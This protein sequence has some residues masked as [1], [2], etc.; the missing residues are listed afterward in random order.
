[1]NISKIVFLFLTCL[2]MC[3][4]LFGQDDLLNM[5]LK[6]AKSEEKNVSATF[7]TTKLINA[8]TNETVHK[9][10]LDFR[11]AH[12]FGNVGKYSEGKSP[13]HTIYGL[14]ASTDIRIAFDYGITDRLTVGISRT[15][16]RENLEG[17]VKYRVLQ[18]TMDNKIPVALTVFGN[19]TYTPVRDE[20]EIYKKAAHR[21]TYFAQAIIAR[22]F[23]NKLS[24]EI[25]P[26]YLHR[27]LVLDPA[28]ENDLFSLGGGVR[29]KITKSTSVI[30]DYFH[31]F[32][33][34]RMD[35]S[36]SYFDP[37]GVGFEI[38]TGGHV[39]SIMFTNSAG[40]LENEFLPYTTDSWAEGGFKFSFNISR[41]FK[42]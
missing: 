33:K 2:F 11:V 25:L 29:Y 36:D 23:S 17:Q 6:E 24:F 38:E 16:I 3:S 4:N 12:R 39:F 7:K 8:Q 22:K 14:D 37:L 19:A 18:Q 30:I 10:T 40:L 13:V 26:G 21:V 9:R 42:L 15:K 5:A 20:L 31:N 32:S 1:M 35:R 27:N 41:N 34:Y 28:D